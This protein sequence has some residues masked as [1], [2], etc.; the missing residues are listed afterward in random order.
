MRSYGAGVTRQISVDWSHNV[1]MREFVFSKG[2]NRDT[3]GNTD[4]I[5]NY[6]YALNDNFDVVQ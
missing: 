2:D 3:I 1:H 5:E 6:A 4:T